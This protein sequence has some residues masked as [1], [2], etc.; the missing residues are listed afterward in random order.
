MPA[1][2]FDS[3]KFQL[4]TQVNPLASDSDFSNLMKFQMLIQDKVV[5]QIQLSKP[6]FNLKLTM[7][8]VTLFA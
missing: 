7:I 5:N 1:M 6:P 3:A 8:I 2:F 4:F